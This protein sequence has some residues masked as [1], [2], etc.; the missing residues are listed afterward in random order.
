MDGYDS[1][2]MLCSLFLLCGLKMA[3]IWEGSIS[4]VLFQ[5]R[6]WGGHTFME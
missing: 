1:Y 3:T 5:W 2:R 4:K 6:I